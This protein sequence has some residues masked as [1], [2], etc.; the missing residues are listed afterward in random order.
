[1]SSSLLPQKC[2][3]CLARRSGIVSEM[4]GK[5]PISSGFYGGC[6]KDF[7]RTEI[8]SPCLAFSSCILL[9]CFVFFVQWHIKLHGL[10]SAK[11]IL[12][13]EHDWYYFTHS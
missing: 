8:R 5:W 3:V 9:N 1:M 4:G 6:F 10:F 11:A 12:V 13:E 2:S 7:F